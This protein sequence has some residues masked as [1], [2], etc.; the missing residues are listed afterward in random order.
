MFSN[1]MAKADCPSCYSATKV[2]GWILRG[3]I[4]TTMTF[5]IEGRGPFQRP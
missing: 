3:S 2:K 1:N 4:E 5:D